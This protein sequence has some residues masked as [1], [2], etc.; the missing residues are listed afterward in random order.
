MKIVLLQFN[1]LK[2]SNKIIVIISIVVKPLS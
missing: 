1:T 2:C